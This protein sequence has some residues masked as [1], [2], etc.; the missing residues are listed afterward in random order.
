MSKTQDSINLSQS[1][2]N[3]S[4]DVSLKE[5]FERV[6]RMETKFDEAIIRN[7]R[8]TRYFKFAM[9]VVV[10]IELINLTLNLFILH[11]QSILSILGGVNG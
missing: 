8:S 11:G 6:V 9:Y 5:L 2:T 3:R 4:N 7:N 10:V 1:Q